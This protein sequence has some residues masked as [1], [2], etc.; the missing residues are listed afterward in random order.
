VTLLVYRRSSP[1]SKVFDVTL[2]LAPG[3]TLTSPQLPS[4]ELA[5]AELFAT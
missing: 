3:D 1:R 2:E 5:L 4:F